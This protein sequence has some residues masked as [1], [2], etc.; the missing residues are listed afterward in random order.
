MTIKTQ[1]LAKF[2]AKLSD[3]SILD[4][5]PVEKKWKLWWIDR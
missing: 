5:E 2:I 3:V 1:A 4:E